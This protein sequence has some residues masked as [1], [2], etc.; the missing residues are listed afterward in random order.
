[1][2]SILCIKAM[3]GQSLIFQKKN[4][5]TNN[6]IVRRIVE[7]ASY[8]NHF[9]SCELTLINSIKGDSGLL[10]LFIGLTLC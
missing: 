7:Y 2:S 8:K 9:I 4:F 1:M 6:F 10:D 5:F 3:Y